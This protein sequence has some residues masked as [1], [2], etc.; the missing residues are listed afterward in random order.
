[1]PSENLDRVLE[2]VRAL[3]AAERQELRARLDTWPAPSQ[4]TQDGLD[5]RL[6]AAGVIDH[7]P[8]PVTDLAP[9]RRWKPLAMK[10]KPLSETVIEERR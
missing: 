8:A 2:E 1:M 3:T 10:A 4:S 6:L 9:Y 5:E 7:V